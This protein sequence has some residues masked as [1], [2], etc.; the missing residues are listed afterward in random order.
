[1]D[2]QQNET[3]PTAY[4]KVYGRLGSLGQIDQIYDIAVSTAGGYRLDNIVVENVK[5]AELCIDWL[6]E[7]RLGHASFMNLV[8]EDSKWKN[9]IIHHPDVP[10]DCT[11]LLDH[12]K[13]IN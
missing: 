6:R 4:G 3:I 10:E 13:L 12:I 2:A 11:R 9:K 8:M 1:M 5:V 7:N